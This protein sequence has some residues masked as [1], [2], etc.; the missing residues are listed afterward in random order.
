MARDLSPILPAAVRVV[1]RT[2]R[3]SG[4]VTDAVPDDYTKTI[5]LSDVSLTR[6][7]LP[8]GLTG[9]PGTTHT[10]RS[11]AIA[12]FNVGGTDP[13]NK[14]ALDAIAMRIAQ[15]FYDWRS[16]SFDRV[17]NGIVVS[18]PSGLIDTIEWSYEATGHDDTAD[19]GDPVSFVGGCT[20]RI[21]SAPWNGEPEELSHLDPAQGQCTEANNGGV[22]VTVT[23]CLEY[24]GPP[25]SCGGGGGKA[26]ATIADGQI[27]G[28]TVT[29]GGAY[30]G[31]PTVRISGDGS[32][33]TGTATISD[34]QLVGITP[35]EPGAGYTY[36]VVSLDGG[37]SKL[38]M[39]RYRYCFE[40]GRIVSR[41]V[42]VD[43]VV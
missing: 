26:T 6:S 31:T 28:F 14:T 21:T 17:Y 30:T 32:G 38:Q 18:K 33:A 24:L 10:V 25:A 5:Q 3:C 12:L 19:F 27:T 39:T 37:G 42:S 11:E 34:G 16:V 4:G 15:D 40:A 43:T 2:R 36:A 13:T 7:D 8:T 1:F 35:G 41:F 22:P 29:A 20:T 23:P 9:T